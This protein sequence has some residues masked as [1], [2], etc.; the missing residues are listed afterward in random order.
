MF[1]LPPLPYDYAALEP[2]IDTETMRIHHTKHH[3]AYVQNLNDALKGK[4]DLLNMDI[5]ELISNLK[6]VPEELQTKVKN[7][8]GGHANHSLFWKLMTPKPAKTPSHLLMSLI[9]KNFK[10][11]KEFQ[12][13][14]SATAMGRFG[15]GWAW[16]VVHGKKLEIIDTPNQESPLSSGLTPILALD[17]WEQAYYLRYQNRRAEY[18][19]AW[20]NVVN[21][22]EVEKLYSGAQK[23]KTR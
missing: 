6:K 23:K 16:L 5:F 13:E 19:D 2:F 11:F 15:S 4:E 10:D 8:G 14:F 12:E 3:A 22:E 18:I 1:S 20:W 17:V 7:Q 21:W 9:K